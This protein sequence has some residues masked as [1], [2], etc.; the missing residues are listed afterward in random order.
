MTNELDELGPV[1]YLVVEFPPDAAN[2]NGE[3]AA[4]LATLADAG[5]IRILDLLILRK[6]EQG[7][8]EAFEMDDLDEV[9]EMVHL[10]ADIAEILAAD[11]VVHLAA[12][13][14]NGT[15]AGVDRLG[16]QLGG[17]VRLS[18]P[19]GR[20]PVGRDGSHP[21]PGHH[22]IARG[23]RGLDHRRRLTCHFVQLEQRAAVSSADPSPG[24]LPSSAP[25][26]SSPTASVDAA[27][28]ATTVAMTAATVADTVTSESGV[29]G[30]LSPTLLGH[31]PTAAPAS[32]PRRP[33]ARCWPVP[34]RS[35][36]RRRRAA[37]CRR[38]R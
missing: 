5:I 23:R 1:D 11:D 12:A 38:R 18:G 28:V 27:T 10:E 21:D 33:R 13:M 2:F 32:W 25:L 3:M 37:W 26:P 6:D 35:A 19:A 22:R 34:C 20:R 16:E 30:E 24:P 9:S 17:S 7:E 29:G 14:E 36:S 31:A 8:I 4:E 15:T